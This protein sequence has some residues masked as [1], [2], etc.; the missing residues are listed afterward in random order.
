MAVRHRTACVEAVQ[1]HPESCMSEGGKGMMANFLKMKG[2]TWGGE[3][4]WC[5]V[6]GAIASE[7]SLATGEKEGM[8]GNGTSN[9]PKAVQEGDIDSTANTKPEGLVGAAIASGSAMNGTS[10]NTATVPSSNTAANA[11]ST[12]GLPTILNRIHTQRLTDVQASSLIPSTTPANLHKSLALHTSPPLISFVDRIKSTPHTAIMAE[13]KRA[14]PSKGDIAPLASAP[15]QG[16][17]YAMAGA[18]V[19]S[20]LTEPKWFKGGLVDMLAVRNA[21]SSIPNRPAVLRK[22]FIVSTYQ[23]DEARLYGADTILLIVAMLDLDLLKELYTYSVSIGM[24]P[25]V[26]VNNPSEL[27]IAL[28]LGSK[29]IGVNNRNLHDF[30]VDMSTTSRVNAALEGRDVIL[31]ALS[32]ISKP[33]D[34]AGYV[35]EGVKAVLVGESLMRAE[36]TGAF[37]RALVGLEPVTQVKEDKKPLVKICGIRSV[38]DA[39]MAIELGADMIG[40]VLVPGVKRSISRQ[41]AQEIGTLVQTSRLEKSSTSKSTP[42]NSKQQ[43]S[44]F[45]HHAERLASKRKPLLVGVFRNQP[46]SDILDL[47][48]SIPLDIVQLHG[49]EPQEYSNWIPVPVIKTFSVSQNGT[50]TGG[51]ITRPGLNAHILL[52]AAGAGGQTGGGGEGK[53]FPWEFAKEVIENGE[54]G[55]GGVGRL[56]VILAGGLHDGNVGA[57]IQQAGGVVGV[58]VS[59]GVEGSDGWKDRGKVERFIKAVKG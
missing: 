46:L 56:P 21:I 42:S 12:P 59:S 19:I 23:I 11:S 35:A 50:I 28:D 43:S 18:S 7:A 24:E 17:K 58:D 2:G 38:E 27:N 9:G 32:G 20:V 51:E 16:I 26:E 6:P 13:I 52:D 36:D 37:L 4:A 1:Y 33:E 45:T 54:V 39:K 49:T 40:I 10:S 44:W 48:D 8:S 41:L 14:S 47:V 5:G 15:E 34:V 25:L 55:M 57:A 22:D 3:N 31:C 53:S 29:V 30:Q